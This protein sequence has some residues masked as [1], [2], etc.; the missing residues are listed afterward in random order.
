MGRLKNARHEL[1]CQYYVTELNGKLYNATQAAIKAKFSEKTAAQQ[2][3]R[4]LRNVKI[5]S[6]IDELKEDALKALE[7]DKLW[8]L[9]RYKKIVDDKIDNYLQFEGDERGNIKINMKNSADIDTWNISEIKVGK[10]GQFSFKLNDKK[11]A[12]QK[13]GEYMTLFS[14]KD[15]EESDEDKLQKQLENIKTIA[16][17]MQNPRPNRSIDDE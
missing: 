17:Y 13:I 2:A 16:Q 4:L 11:A 12:M 9:Q 15:E 3:S 6:R 14:N 7:I 1:F 10:D 8:L 5:R